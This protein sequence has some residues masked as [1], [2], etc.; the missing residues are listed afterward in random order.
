MSSRD[1]CLSKFVSS[2]SFFF[3]INTSILWCMCWKNTKSYQDV[4]QLYHGT[5]AGSLVK[6]FLHINIWCTFWWHWMKMLGDSRCKNKLQKSSTKFWHKGRRSSMW[7]SDDISRREN[8]DWWDW[9]FGAIQSDWR[10][11]DMHCIIKAMKGQEEI[12]C[13]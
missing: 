8:G 7:N 12:A 3:K 13:S 5:V 1:S 10:L 9:E 2:E 4:V 6:R 11:L